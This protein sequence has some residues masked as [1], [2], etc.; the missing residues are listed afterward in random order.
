ML[1]IDRDHLI[2]RIWS[3]SIALSLEIANDYCVL[4]FTFPRYRLLHCV[5]LVLIGMFLEIGRGQILHAFGFSW[6]SLK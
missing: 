3:I 6:N 5:G 4:Y 1:N 2:Y